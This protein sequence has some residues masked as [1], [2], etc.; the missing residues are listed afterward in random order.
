MD[1]TAVLDALGSSA[2][3]VAGG[4]VVVVLVLIFWAF[5][6][7]RAIEFLPPRIGEQPAGPQKASPPPASV[8][9]NIYEVDNAMA[10]YGAIAPN[11][12]Q[13]N[14]VNL[15]AT[16]LEVI[17]R[18]EEFGVAKPGLRVLDLGGGTGQNVATH[19]FNQGNICWTYVD[20][21]PGMVEQLQQHLAGRPLYQHLQV[22]VED[23]N[24]VHLRVQ[25][26][27]QDII[28]LNLVLSSMPLL[29]DFRRLAAL[30][31]PGGRMIISDINPLY[32]HAH[33]LY[34]ATA[35]DG[36]QVAMRTKAVQPLEIVTR[37]RDAELQLS[38]MSQIGAAEIS[39]SFVAVFETAVQL[40][41]RTDRPGDSKATLR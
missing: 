28:L 35:A 25:P 15:L 24:R 10:F 16:H 30:L 11:Y 21:C 26:Q 41:S 5:R 27:S 18:I 37:A 12:D 14:S 31:A 34:T 40:S 6:Q 9:P 2:G 1:F 29:P 17:S 13:R 22:H 38:D 23:I 33:P 20:F 3:Y 7:G 4:F 36:M 39:Y 8:Q 19:F 32:T